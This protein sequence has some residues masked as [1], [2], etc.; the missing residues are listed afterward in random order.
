MENEAWNIFA[1]SGRV[2]D[3]LRYKRENRCPENERETRGEGLSL[4]DRTGEEAVW[5]RPLR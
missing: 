4:Q 5:E 1:E 3:Y 2:E